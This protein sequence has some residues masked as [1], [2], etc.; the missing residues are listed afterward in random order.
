[1]RIPDSHVVGPRGGG[2]ERLF[3][4]GSPCDCSGYLSQTPGY[5]IRVITYRRAK[6][7]GLD[8]VLL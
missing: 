6:K 3:S 4:G 1:M 2:L 5:S 7:V 8:L